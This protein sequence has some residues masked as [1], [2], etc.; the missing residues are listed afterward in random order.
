M[1]IEQRMNEVRFI[2]CPWCNQAYQ[3]IPAVASRG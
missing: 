1:T 3:P 2:G